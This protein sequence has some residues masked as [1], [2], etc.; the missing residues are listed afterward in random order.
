MFECLHRVRNPLH[1]FIDVRVKNGGW[2]QKPFS[3]DIQN[4]GIE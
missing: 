4:Q 2:I 3:L 1:S